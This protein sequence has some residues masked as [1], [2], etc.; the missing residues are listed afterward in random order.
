[1]PIIVI[2]TPRLFQKLGSCATVVTTETCVIRRQ[3]VIHFVQSAV[4]ICTVYIYIF[5]FFFCVPPPLRQP[6]SVFGGVQYITAYISQLNF[7]AR[8]P[9][10]PHSLMRVPTRMN[11]FHMHD[12]IFCCPNE[13]GLQHIISPTYTHDLSHKHGHLFCSTCNYFLRHSRM[14]HPT[15]MN[16]IP[17]APFCLASPTCMHE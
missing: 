5:F 10:L 1:M 9:L 8:L 2:P 4:S 13:R 11:D 7:D 6:H 15:H 14:I 3:S 12:R 17:H 16:L